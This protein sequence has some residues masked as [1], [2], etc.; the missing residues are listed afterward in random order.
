M[1]YTYSYADFVGDSP[2]PRI[3]GT[4]AEHFVRYNR[5]KKGAQIAY[6]DNES[7]Q[8]LLVHPVRLRQL[9]LTALRAEQGGFFYSNGTRGYRD[10]QMIEVSTAERRGPAQVAIGDMR[11]RRFLQILLEADSDPSSQ[12]FGLEVFRRTGNYNRAIPPNKRV[13]SLATTG[14]HLSLHTH[15]KVLEDCGATYFGRMIASFLAT[16]PIWRGVGW[17]GVNGYEYSQKAPHIERILNGSKTGPEK[18]MVYIHLDKQDTHPEEW[19]R[20]EIRCLDAPHDPWSS[21]M[22]SAFTALA[23]R[24]LE[25][26]KKLPN[27][28]KILLQLPATVLRQVSK[29]IAMEKAYRRV[30]ERPDISALGHQRLCFELFG[31]LA[32]KIELPLDEYAA[33]GEGHKVLDEI[34]KEIDTPVEE[35]NYRSISNR[36][37]SAARREVL[38]HYAKKHNR[39]TQLHPSNWFLAGVDLM[40]DQIAP[41]D[42]AY[43]RWQSRRSEVYLPFDAQELDPTA[44]NDKKIAIPPQTRAMWRRQFFEPEVLPQV[45]KLGWGRATMKNEKKIAQQDAYATS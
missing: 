44:E 23:M 32:S 14:Y 4:E 40:F 24:A 15:K 45:E 36:V 20:V 39:P 7:I 13:D 8:G 3:M 5:G 43:A 42:L 22:G 11:A 18:P 31:E 6:P 1:N 9:G 2:P 12:H 35:R 29:D 10:L 17:I 28:E 27:M 21:W 25:H 26:Y 34:E 16:T 33:I 30:S 38:L 41:H 19:P 37:P